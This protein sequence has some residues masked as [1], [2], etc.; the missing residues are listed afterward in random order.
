MSIY[1]L[2]SNIISYIL[3]GDEYIINRYR[4]ESNQGAEFVMPPI[5]Y[6]EVKRWLLERGAKNKATEF[7]KLCQ[8]VPLGEL[9]RNVWNTASAIYVKAR[10]KG[11][12]INDADLIIAAFCIVNGHVLVTNNP[13]HFDEIDGLLLVNWKH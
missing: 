13:R 6:F 11:K 4:Q 3:K 5:A 10:K 12:P 2:D 1:A 7:D 9:D 8:I